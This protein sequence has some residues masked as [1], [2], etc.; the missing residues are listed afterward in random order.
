MTESTVP[1]NVGT[2]LLA[3]SVIV[4]L[5]VL[6]AVLHW[7]A[8]Q[9][10]PVGMFL[11]VV[12]AVVF[13]QAP[14]ETIAVATGKG[15][16]DAVFILLVIWPSLLLYQVGV[17]SGAFEGLRQGLSRYSRNHVFLVLAFGWVFASFMQGI[18]GF[19]A[20]I[21]IVAPLLLAIGV[22]PVY[23]VAIPLIGHAW[24][25]M[26]GTLGVGWIA[27]L[28]VVDIDD[29]LGTAL[30][31]AALLA[32]VTLVSG[33]TIAWMA[34]K[35]PAL[36]LAWPLILIV[37]ALHGGIQFV[38]M[39]WEPLLSNFLGGAA[40]LAA[41]YPLSRWS[42]FSRAADDITDRP[43]MRD[44]GESDAEEA[45]EPAVMSLPWALLPYALL[46]AVSVL[47]LT[48]PP[49][50]D[51][52]GRFELGFP[53]P[54]VTTGYD[55]TTEGESTYDPIA[56]LTH[57][58][59]A[60]IV[61]VVVTWL[62]FRAQ[63]FFTAQRRKEGEQPIFSGLVTNA[64]PASLAILSFLVLASVMEHSGQIEVL[65]EGIDAV[66]PPWLSAF[67]AAFIGILG[68]F[69]T[70]SSTSANVLFGQ[71]QQN[72]ATGAGLNP[73]GFLAAQGAGGSVGNTFAPANI[74]LGTS[75]AGIVGQEGRVLRMTLPWT[76]AVGVLLGL[77]TLFFV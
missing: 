65:A 72:I 77:L 37:A 7:K 11:A 21:A 20:P 64:A 9:A 2:W 52:L 51:L 13:F 42:R 55:V 48:I 73:T 68:A 12:V 71:L 4:L 1:I 75:T 40:A 59:F 23:A 29:E 36:R 53:F 58:G 67:S 57:P 39:Y 50:E 16:W 54:E 74:V 49:V 62:A 47:T 28:Q 69:I 63:G 31:T 34:G 38:V 66:L 45:E 35:G 30:A 41:L 33:V 24:A 14:W 10:G 26:Y 76:L 19:G 17:A 5:V 43:A 3:I 70:S 46:T 27:L 32:P 15:I 6:L 25:S 56:P 8:P 60:L 18:A 44:D 61:S 22:R